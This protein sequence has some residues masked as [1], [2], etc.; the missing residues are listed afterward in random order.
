MLTR[1]LRCAGEYISVTTANLVL[2][3]PDRTSNARRM[4][5]LMT[6]NVRRK[7]RKNDDTEIVNTHQRV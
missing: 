5:R 1:G 3:R 2:Q 7:E 6:S 4:E